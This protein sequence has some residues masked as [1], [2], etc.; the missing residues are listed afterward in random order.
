M[1]HAR[2]QTKLVFGGLFIGM[3]LLLTACPSPTQE[4]SL[5]QIRSQISVL[6]TEMRESFGKSEDDRISL[7]KQLND[8]VKV[9]QKSQAD[10]S[11]ASDE[12]RASLTAVDA[13]LDEY[14]TRMAQLNERL[15]FV[16]QTLA[17]RITLLSEQVNEIGREATINS[18][19]PSTR[20]Q[21]TTTPERTPVERVP[22]VQDPEIESDPQAVQMY[23][24]A[25]MAYVNGNFDK[26]VAGF[27]RYLEGYPDSER[28]DLAQYW[29]AESFFSLGEFEAA[30]NEYDTLIMKYPNSDRVPA[31]YFSKAD[32][33][34]KLDR[35]MEAISHLRYIVDQFPTSAA[36][37]RAEER[38]RT[39]EAP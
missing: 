11:A 9:L 25:Y 4:K 38:L 5:T 1:I 31:A 8:D 33:Y 15:E 32:A 35:Q 6:S 34:L 30:L 23:Q 13:K 19:T 37:Q 27:Q 24:T 2:G 10:M 26:A 29:I 7:Y 21:P 22:L 36:A 17:E 14:N 16:E 12:L 18:G 3:L 28:T 39:L 20:S